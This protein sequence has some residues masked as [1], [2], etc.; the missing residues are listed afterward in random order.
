M[1]LER[2]RSRRIGRRM[3]HPPRRLHHPLRRSPHPP[4]RSNHPP[5]RSHHSPP[6]S[7]HHLAGQMD[8]PLRRIRAPPPRT[9]PTPT[10][11]GG[12]GDSCLPVKSVVTKSPPR[13]HFAAER[14][15]VKTSTVTYRVR[16]TGAYCVGRLPLGAGARPSR[17]RASR[18]DSCPSLL[19]RRTS[20]V[21]SRASLLGTGASGGQRPRPVRDWRPRRR[22]SMG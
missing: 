14:A 5:P 13:R 11:S 9:A 18:V 10:R 1:R 17:T 21:V 16:T 20:R 7:R 19:G 8:G 2:R 6:R 15:S 3:N 12:L 4:P 22:P